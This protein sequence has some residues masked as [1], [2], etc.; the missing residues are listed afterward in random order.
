MIDDIRCEHLVQHRKVSAGNRCGEFLEGR[1]IFVLS[2][3]H[4]SL[5][6]ERYGKVAVSP[7]FNEIKRLY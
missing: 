4:S 2:H 1:E 7:P 3:P 5:L 6:H